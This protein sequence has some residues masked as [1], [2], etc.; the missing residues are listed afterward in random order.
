MND[1]NL[2]TIII[3]IAG[4]FLTYLGTKTTNKASIERS[5]VENAERLYAK[6]QTMVDG[7][8]KKVDKLQEEIESLKSKYEKE[9]AYYQA[10]VEKLQDE[11]EELREENAK[12]KGEI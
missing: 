2:T 12:L 7:L 10:E 11:N 4:S 6:Y 8:E 9:I 1:L 3:A 5:N